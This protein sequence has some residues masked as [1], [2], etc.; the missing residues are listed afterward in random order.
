LCRSKS[1]PLAEAGFEFAWLPEKGVIRATI[2]FVGRE[3]GTRVRLTHFAERA[4]ESY[5]S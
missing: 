2:S 3:V 1:I 4:Y 5:L